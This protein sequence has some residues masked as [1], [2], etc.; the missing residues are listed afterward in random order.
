MIYETTDDTT[1]C[2]TWFFNHTD[3]DGATNSVEFAADTWIEALNYFVTFLRGSG[4]TIDS[5][6]IGINSDNTLVTDESWYG[7]VFSG[8]EE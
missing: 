4:Y 8:N 3:A 6:T 1:P 2:N 7:A 5:K